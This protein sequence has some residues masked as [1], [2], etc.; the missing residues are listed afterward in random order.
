[1]QPRRLGDVVLLIF[2]TFQEHVVGAVGE[3]RRCEHQQRA[4]H[5]AALDHDGRHRAGAAGHHEARRA[6]EK[7]VAPD[8]PCRLTHRHRNR[9]GD[10]AGVDHEIGGDGADER[11][12]QGFDVERNRVSAQPRIGQAGR[13]HGHGF[14]GHAE[15]GAV[16]RVVMARVQPALRECPGDGDQDGRLRTEEQQRHQVGGVRD[17]QGGAAAARD[18]QPHL[19]GGGDARAAQQRRER[20]EIGPA[21]RKEQRHDA[22]AGNR[23]GG[24]VAPRRRRKPAPAGDVRRCVVQDGPAQHH[25]HRTSQL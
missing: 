9:A 17:R 11:S 22:G 4:P 18:W 2:E 13:R 16:P 19:P 25:G 21:A 24:D 10:Q 12:G 15:D 23:H 20:L 8:L 7:A 6:P 14:G 5:A 3:V 1:M